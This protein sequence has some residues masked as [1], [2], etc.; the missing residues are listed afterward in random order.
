[1]KHKHLFDLYLIG[2]IFIFNS[3]NT[4]ACCKRLMETEKENYANNRT[5]ARNR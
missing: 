2:M 3:L 5:N 4:N 1:M